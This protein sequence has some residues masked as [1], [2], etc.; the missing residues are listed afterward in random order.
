MLFM[1]VLYCLSIGIN[2]LDGISRECRL[3][4][5]LQIITLDKTPST[6]T[7]RRFF[8]DSNPYVMKAVF[9]YTIIEFNDYGFI[10]F[11]KLY[12][13]STDAL[14][15]GSKQYSLT[16]KK[17]EV[18]KF[19][20][21]HDLI[22][23]FSLKSKKRLLR[24]L[25]EIGK[26]LDE[27]DTEI[28][29]YIR[30]VKRNINLYN[31][32]IWEKLPQLERIME[33]RDLN[34]ISITF[35]ESIM[36]HT[37]KGRTDFGFLIHE[38]M[39]EEKIVFSPVLSN[40]PNDKHSLEDIIQE[41]KENIE[42]IVE[43]Q[44]MFGIRR[45]YK[46]LTEI[47]NNTM[48]VFDSGYYEIENLQSAD[49]HELNVLILPKRLATQINNQIREDNDLPLKDKNKQNPENISKKSFKRELQ[50]YRCKAGHLLRL[51]EQREVKKRDGS[52]EKLPEHWRE[53]R[54]KFQCSECAS[55]QY[56]SCCEYETIVDTMTPLEYNMIIKALNKRYQKIYSQRFPCS[57]GINGYLKGKEGIL[58]FMISDTTACKNQL[59]L[60][61][62]G[63]NLQRKINLKGTAY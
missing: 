19:L 21:E 31:K 27:T 33:E 45:N 18:F 8:T 36:M 55:C 2:D 34:V 39:T 22:H 35:P 50:G 29:K 52:H 51:I 47:L 5:V 14:A 3:N 61:N 60:L 54:Y 41:I 56:N 58:Y 24:E 48:L 13:D 1:M 9:L 16:S 4:N 59:Y 40:L 25:E 30:L 57:E 7:F 12:V 37:K 38:V 10:N 53:N 23:D 46:E 49:K 42:I 6:S 63:Y 11:K 28:K 32:D 17:I 44:K 62:I 26:T 43:L 15:R 20:N